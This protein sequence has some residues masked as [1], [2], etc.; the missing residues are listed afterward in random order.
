VSLDCTG[1]AA[2][3]PRDVQRGCSAD[4]RENGTLVKL[5]SDSLVL[6]TTNSTV[7]YPLSSVTLL[8][9]R[10]G[11]TSHWKAGTLV[12]FLGGTALTFA[13]LNSGSPSTTSFCDSTHN[14]DAI[15]GEGACLL[16]AGV[17]G[18]LPGG[19]VGMLVGSLRRT[20]QWEEVSLG[21]VG[22]TLLPLGPRPVLVVSVPLR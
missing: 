8:E 22:L 21:G 18:G 15:G 20:D 17:I 14:Q 10:R 12:G 13:V 5:L 16:V 3:L 11:S 19:L 7:T 2:A 4:G 1:Q 6:E 9:T